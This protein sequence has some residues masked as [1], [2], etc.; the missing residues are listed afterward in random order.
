MRG[1]HMSR[2]RVELGGIRGRG[3]SSNHGG[4]DGGTQRG[5]PS[6]AQWMSGWEPNVGSKTRNTNMIQKV[7]G[8][9]NTAMEVPRTMAG[10][11]LRP[12]TE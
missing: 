9:R 1:A 4:D 5:I 7:E 10:R 6:K 8:P 2:V 11:L 12:V 3:L